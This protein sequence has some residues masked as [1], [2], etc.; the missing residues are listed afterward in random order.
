MKVI[1]EKGKKLLSVVEAGF[2]C[3]ADIPMLTLKAGSRR[4]TNIAR[5]IPGNFPYDPAP[6]PNGKWFIHELRERHDKYRAPWYIATNAYQTVETWEVSSES[7]ELA[8][9][10]PSGRKVIDAEYGIHFS[11]H[12]TT[13]GCIKVLKREDLE[14]LVEILR[15]AIVAREKISL[16]VKD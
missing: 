13:Q 2:S 4:R 10:K 16:E 8:Y 15:P 9:V 12:P 3:A 14:A 7:G 1:F 11:E 5:T 6:F